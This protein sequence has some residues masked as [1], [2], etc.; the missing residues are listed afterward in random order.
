MKC[1]YCNKDIPRGGRVKTDT[2]TS[3]WFCSQNC[4]KNYIENKQE[5]VKNKPTPPKSDFTILK[6]FINEIYEEDV[7]WPLTIKQV[8]NL[9]NNYE[10][11]YRDLY[12][13][14]KY[15]IEIERYIPNTEYTILQFEQFIEP[16]Q[17]L[18]NEIKDKESKAESFNP[19]D[20]IIYI[21]PTK[22]KNRMLKIKFRE[23]D[24]DCYTI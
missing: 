5:K 21:K 13:I 1:K 20:D 23:D 3:Y 6:D 14:L 9:T 10:L 24:D 18:Q 4:Y 22:Q 15:A 2:L 7:N 17:Q 11:T 19:E 12:D 16:W 8:K